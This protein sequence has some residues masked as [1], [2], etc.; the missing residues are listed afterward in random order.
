MLTV[1]NQFNNVK[2]FACLT[3]GIVSGCLPDRL[4]ELV[5]RAQPYPPQV[6]QSVERIA[7]VATKTDSI[8]SLLA[9]LGNYVT[10][11]KEELRSQGTVSGEATTQLKDFSHCADLL[12]FVGAHL[13]VLHLKKDELSYAEQ[14]IALAQ[15]Q[16][17]IRL[18]LCTHR[19]RVCDRE[20]LTDPVAG[21]GQRSHGD[22]LNGRGVVSPDKLLI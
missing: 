12:G 1:G 9:V 21:L 13:D 5:Q 3:D 2:E 14:R 6:F 8:P 7:L 10:A 18:A 20:G 16:D 15:I 22:F 4:Q 11:R 19:V 17:V